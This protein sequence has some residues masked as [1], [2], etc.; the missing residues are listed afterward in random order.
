MTDRE[1]VVV[2]AGGSAYGLIVGLLL[3]VVLL[4][5]VWFVMLD[6]RG[7]PSTRVNDHTDNSVPM[8]DVAPGVPVAA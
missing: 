5:G 8:V 7:G 3:A 1:T 6:G 2:A 4:L